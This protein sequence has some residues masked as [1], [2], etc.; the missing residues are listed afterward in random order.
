[1]AAG[2]HGNDNDASEIDGQGRGV[3][4][5]LPAPRSKNKTPRRKINALFNPAA[6]EKGIETSFAGTDGC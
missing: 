5:R 3:S 4:D 2:V 6:V 1:L